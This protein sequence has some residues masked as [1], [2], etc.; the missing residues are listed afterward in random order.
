M[1]PRECASFADKVSPW[2]DDV[3]SCSQG[4]FSPLIH[5]HTNIYQHLWKWLEINPYHYVDV[6]LL[7]IYVGFDGLKLVLKSR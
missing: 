2:I 5:L 4:V 6:Y 7:C 1:D 3:S